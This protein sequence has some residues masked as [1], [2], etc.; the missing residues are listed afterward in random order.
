MASA[1]NSDTD[2]SCQHRLHVNNALKVVN[3]NIKIES[4]DGTDCMR[5]FSWIFIIIDGFIYIGSSTLNYE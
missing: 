3:D 4:P 1:I 2:N 5:N